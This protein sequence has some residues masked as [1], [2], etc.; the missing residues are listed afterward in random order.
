MKNQIT[1]KP[2]LKIIALF[3]PVWDFETISEEPMIFSGDPDFTYKNGGELTRLVLD[4]LNRLGKTSE[5]PNHL[6]PVIDT[7]SHML[8]KGMYPAIGG[9][10]CDAITH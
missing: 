4:E 7:R 1:L 2:E 10:H 6:Y 3:E 8:M 5:C 9:R